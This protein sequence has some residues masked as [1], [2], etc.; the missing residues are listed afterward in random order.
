[1]PA[2]FGGGTRTAWV[3]VEKKKKAELTAAQKSLMALAQA[4]G[5]KSISAVKQPGDEKEDGGS[6]TKES[7]LQ[8]ENAEEVRCSCLE[9]EKGG[10]AEVKCGR[11]CELM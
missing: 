2:V 4:G 8:S 3:A 1:V 7:E 6:S 5:K 9:E 11:R 10:L